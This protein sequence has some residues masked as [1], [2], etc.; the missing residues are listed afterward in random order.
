MLSANVLQLQEVGDFEAQ[1]CLPPQNLIRSTKL[2][3]TTEPPISCRCCYKLG[4]FSVEGLSC[5]VCTVPVRWLASSFYFLALALCDWKIKC[6]CKCVGLVSFKVISLP[7]VLSY[8]L[9]NLFLLWS[10]YTLF[11][12]VYQFLLSIYSNLFLIFDVKFW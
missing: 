6:A 3:L 5:P 11:K 4:F 8:L 2:H 7:L 9:L 12:D 1:N 10:V